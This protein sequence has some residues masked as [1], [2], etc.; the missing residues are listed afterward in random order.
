[1]VQI[2]SGGDSTCALDAQGAV[3][4]WGWLRD[5]GGGGR[6]RH[7]VTEPRPITG[8]GAGVRA[9][10]VGTPSCAVMAD[11]TVRCWG[12][13]LPAAERQTAAVAGRAPR[14]AGPPAPPPLEPPP[15]PPPPTYRCW[16][17]EQICCGDA[18][19]ATEDAC[20]D[21][22]AQHGVTDCHC[23]RRQLSRLLREQ[24]GRQT[25]L[26][27][28]CLPGGGCRDARG[29]ECQPSADLEALCDASLVEHQKAPPATVRLRWC[30]VGTE[31]I[32]TGPPPRDGRR[33]QA[34]AE[35]E[36]RR[37]AR[38]QAA[39]EAAAAAS[40]RLGQP[41]AVVEP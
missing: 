17:S 8:L 30:Y 4:C 16:R 14:G 31:R 35:R 19:A 15:P 34:C 10:T 1:V 40:G 32:C 21:Q 12:L 22:R 29:G 2:S 41:C 3:L 5:P 9:V 38:S 28:H 7:A 18:C 33:S 26:S 37:C 11:R 20:L 13:Q 25:D 23:E 36:R 24:A 6:K 27:C 39:C